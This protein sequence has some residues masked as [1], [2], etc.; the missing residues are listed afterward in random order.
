MT[1]QH[2]RLRSSR[3]YELMH[4]ERARA[5]ALHGEKPPAPGPSPALRAQ[6]GRVGI[7]TELYAGR[8]DL[9]HGLE[10]SPRAGRRAPGTPVRGFGASSEVGKPEQVDEEAAS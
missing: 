2:E 1:T 6:L 7:G 8:P 9:I 3:P 10:A 5:H 4:A